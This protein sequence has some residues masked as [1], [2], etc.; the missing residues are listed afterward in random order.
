MEKDTINVDELY[1]NS[2]NL[3]EFIGKVVAETSG[4]ISTSSAINLWKI[5][6]RAEK[7]KGNG[8]NTSKS[9]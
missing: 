8:N 5:Y 7:E 2:K 1:D 3:E 6:K 4:L 9:N